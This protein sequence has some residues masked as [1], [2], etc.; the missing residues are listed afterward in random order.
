MST[1]QMLGFFEHKGRPRRNAAGRWC[2]RCRVGVHDGARA[3]D[4]STIGT[5]LITVSGGRPQAM[6]VGGVE[7]GELGD[8]PVDDVQDRD[9]Q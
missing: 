8:L 5:C 3:L 4:S 9:V 6:V 7:S 1:G 2:S